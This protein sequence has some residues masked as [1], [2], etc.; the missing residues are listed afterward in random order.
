MLFGLFFYLI[1][2]TTVHP[3]YLT[4]LLFLSIFTKYR[5]PIV[6][7]YTIML[8]Y[9]AYQNPVFKENYWCIAIEYGI[10]F[11][12]ML[13]EFTNSKKPLLPA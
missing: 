8:S 6:W 10:V 2:T 1:T 7:T 11:G 9:I 12:M 3:W 4:T 5:F 13:W